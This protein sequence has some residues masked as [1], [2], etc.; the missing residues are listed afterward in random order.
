MPRPTGPSP[1]WI[2]HS[3]R[4]APAVGGPVRLVDMIGAGAA[5][6]V[7]TQLI[8]GPVGQDEDAA[9][10][11]LL[12]RTGRAGRIR[13]RGAIGA[14]PANGDQVGEDGRRPENAGRLRG[15][16]RRDS[17][18]RSDGGIRGPG[19]ARSGGG[20][21]ASGPG[22]ARRSGP[23]AHPSLSPD[24]RHL[25]TRRLDGSDSRSLSE[26]RHL[27]EET[28]GE[29]RAIA[30]GLR[31]SILD[32]LGLVASIRQMLAEAGG[33][34]GFE[35]SFGVTGAEQRLPTSRRTSALPHHPGGPF[36]HRAPR[37]TASGGGG[38]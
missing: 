26:L 10:R 5:A 28:V 29:L 13:D 17:A 31:P 14:L 22:T 36:Q 12:H 27:V 15:R 32:D 18:S 21:P 16:H 1:P 19:G 37:G 7:L 38:N 20:T 9:G 2:D 34:Q 6:Q 23:V 35:T 8:S 24:R 11:S 30:R 3:G 4:R 33:R 25:G